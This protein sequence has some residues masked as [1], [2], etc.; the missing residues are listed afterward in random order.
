[1]RMYR[2]IQNKSHCDHKSIKKHR[3]DTQWFDTIAEARAEALELGMPLDSVVQEL[4]IG[5]KGNLI[6]TVK[7]FVN[8]DYTVDGVI[9]TVRSLGS[10]KQMAKLKV[11]N[12]FDYTPE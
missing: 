11:V 6:Q 12:L 4:N 9:Q 10:N 8:G 3:L 5:D 2:V 7:N 1:M